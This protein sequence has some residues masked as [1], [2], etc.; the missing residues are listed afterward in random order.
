MSTSTEGSEGE[1]NVFDAF[2][3]SRYGPP[4]QLFVWILRVVR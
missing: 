4:R 1:G 2:D 3:A